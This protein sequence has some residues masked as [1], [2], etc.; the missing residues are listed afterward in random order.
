MNSKELFSDKSVDTSTDK[1]FIGVGE[2]SRRW[3][4][5]PSAIYALKAGT[6]RLKR[7]RF[8]RSIKFLLIDVERTEQSIINDCGGKNNVKKLK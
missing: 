3:A 1:K 6:H 4:I 5:S 8:G 7:Y 2:L